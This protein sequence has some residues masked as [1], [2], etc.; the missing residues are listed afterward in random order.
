[1]NTDDIL[2]FSI[3]ENQR[4]AGRFPCNHADRCDINVVARQ[5]FAY[6]LTGIVITRAGD[7][8]NIRPAATGSDGLVGAFTAKCHL[9]LVTR[10]GFAR[11]RERFKVKNVIGI[12]TAKDD[13][14]ACG[15]HGWVVHLRAPPV[16]PGGV[17]HTFL[18]WCPSGSQRL[19]DSPFTA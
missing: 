19:P 1:M 3:D 5:L 15:F 7:K 12:D 4:H 18:Y 13:E 10:D 2:T 9:I 17:C 8:R 16:L 11:C 14:V 6:S